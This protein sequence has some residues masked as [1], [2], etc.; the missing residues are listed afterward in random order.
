MT[1]NPGVAF[2]F[3]GDG[4]DGFADQVL[5]QLVGFAGEEGSDLAFVEDGLFP[6]AGY[7]PGSC[8]LTVSSSDRRIHS[9]KAGPWLVLASTMRLNSSRSQR[10]L[11]VLF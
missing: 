10:K 8:T 4:L 1:P 6:A 5:R 7:A 2:A 9:G 3:S 11:V